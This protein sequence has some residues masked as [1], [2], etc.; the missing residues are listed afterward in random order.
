MLLLN[1]VSVYSTE[2]RNATDEYRQRASIFSVAEGG[3]TKRWRVGIA[4]SGRVQ[5][6]HL[7][8]KL[9]LIEILSSRDFNARIRR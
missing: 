7:H 6:K 1:T 9:K 5:I 2:T 3:K 4:A 8:F